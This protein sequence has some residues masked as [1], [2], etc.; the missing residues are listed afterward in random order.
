[1]RKRWP[2]LCAAAGVAMI[3]G[4]LAQGLIA[5]ARA[6]EAATPGLALPEGPAAPYKDSG[7]ILCWGCPP[8]PAVP[9]ASSPCV[10]GARQPCG[11]YCGLGEQFC[12]PDGLGWGPCIEHYVE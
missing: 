2:Y 7:A 10:P 9:L 4:V 6:A 11:G 3:V 8:V 1:M 12:R 5:P